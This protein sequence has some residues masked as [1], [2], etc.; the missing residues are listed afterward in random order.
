MNAVPAVAG[1]VAPATE[2][3][4]NLGETGK[5]IEFYNCFVRKMQER[6]GKNVL[7]PNL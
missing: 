4:H 7:M 2:K 3:C 5:L 1:P 6:T